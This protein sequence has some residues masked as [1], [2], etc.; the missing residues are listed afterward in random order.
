MSDLKLRDRIA[1]VTGGESGIGAACVAALAAAGADVAMIYHANEQKADASMAAVTALGRRSVAAMADVGSEQDVEA[2][3][4][5]ITEA[6]GIPDILVNSAG[7]NMAGVPVTKMKLEQW[8]RMLRTDLTGTFLASRRFVRD[9]EAARRPGAI[10]N[11]TSIHSSVMRAGGADYDA[12]KG[13][14]RNLTRTM[15]LETARLGITVNAI[16]P[17]IILTPM[18]ERA[19]EDAGYRQGLEKNIPLGRAGTPDEVAGVAVFLA[20]P[21]AAYITGAT[22]TIDGGLS[23]ELGQG[24]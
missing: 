18:N 22:I 14:Q 24:A 15:A 4:D 10:I 8:D 23:L 7:I 9:L 3:F 11:I 16:A 17:G 13:G 19:T 12:A 6:L 20:S 1:V 2:A 21:A 5:R